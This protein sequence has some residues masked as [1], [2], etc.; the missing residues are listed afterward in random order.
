MPRVYPAR[1]YHELC[2]LNIAARGLPLLAAQ[3]Y[4]ALHP[5]EERYPTWVTVRDAV[6][7]QRRTGNPVPAPP[8]GRPPRPQAAENREIVLRCVE[9]N[10]HISTREIQQQHGICHVTAHKIIRSARLHPYHYTRVQELNQLDLPGRL[11][12]SQWLVNRDEENEHFVDNINFSDESLFVRVGYFNIHN[13]HTYAVENPRLT[14]PNR[15]TQ[16]RLSINIWMGIYQDKLIGPHRFPNRLTA[17]EY[18]RFLRDVLPQLLDDAGV[19]EDNRQTMWWQQDGAP[20]HTALVSREA[21]RELFPGRWIGAH[22]DVHWPARSPDFNPLDFFLWGALKD[23]MYKNL[24]PVE[25]EEQLFESV[26][27]AAATI[28]PEMIL[29]AKRNLIRRARCC[30][31]QSG[32]HVEQFMK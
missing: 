8:R 11:R 10:P 1:V 14:I 22:G 20:P 3:M 19:D 27:E 13:N 25:N 28:S 9:E 32:G 26:Q 29:A 30:I 4:E 18:C 5:G 7:R 16:H 17:V 24:V 21:L 15:S 12:F 31:E 6:E 23:K 2:Q